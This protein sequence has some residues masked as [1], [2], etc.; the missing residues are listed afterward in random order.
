MSNTLTNKVVAEKVSISVATL[1]RWIPMLEEAGYIFQSAGAIRKLNDDN[2]PVLKRMKVFS[3]K[4]N[5]SLEQAAIKAVDWHKRQ[6]EKH[7]LSEDSDSVPDPNGDVYVPIAEPSEPEIT[8]E[9]LW[10]DEELAAAKDFD[11]LMMNLMPGLF[12]K[13]KETQSLLH[14]KWMTIRAKLLH[15]S[16]SVRSSESV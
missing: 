10:T 2:I 8:S 9:I 6:K 7:V 15:S 4:P 3:D 5:N 14:S 12:W 1:K 11:E 13:G 16:K